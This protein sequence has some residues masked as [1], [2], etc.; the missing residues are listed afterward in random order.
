MQER[1]RPRRRDGFG[2]A[3]LN[4][5]GQ[6]D[7]PA[8]RRSRWSAAASTPAIETSFEAMRLNTRR[9]AVV[10]ERLVSTSGPAR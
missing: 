8:P 6:T 3:A 10:R 1:L 9:L 4:L 7:L 5:R 2:R